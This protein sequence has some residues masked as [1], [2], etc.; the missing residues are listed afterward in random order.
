MDITFLC[1]LLFT[2]PGFCL[3]WTFRHFA[4]RT[5]I[6][7]FEYAVWSFVWG[8]LMFALSVYASKDVGQIIFDLNNPLKLFSTSLGMGL[9]LSI[10]FA[11]PF[12]F[13]AA[14]LNSMGLFYWIDKMLFALIK[15]L[16]NKNDK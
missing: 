11:F 4:R 10:V 12:G 8:T 9:G 5:E 3:V 13:M 6:G 7:D 14:T 15:F 1:Y 16:S 2:I